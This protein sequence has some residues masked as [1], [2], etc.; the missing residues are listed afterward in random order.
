[1]IPVCDKIES[2]G[3]AQV[4]RYT[5]DQFIDT[6]EL[7]GGSFS[8][9]EDSILFTSNKTGIFNVYSMPT[10]GGKP[11]QLTYSK[12]E[13]T[14]AL[15]Y[16]P[17]DPRILFQRDQGGNENNHLFILEP[18]GKEKDLTPGDRVRAQFHGWSLDGK[19]FYYQTNERDL[20]FFDSFKMSVP[21]L[22]PTLL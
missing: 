12:A 9:E 19:A 22:E 3:T 11:R 6:I 5:I 15:S 4:P 7:V 8:D 20:R 13:A 10:A 17:D 14:Y 21:L 16:F 1:M 18:D 2:E